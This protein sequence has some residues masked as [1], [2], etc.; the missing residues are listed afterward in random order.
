MDGQSGDKQ[1]RWFRTVVNERCARRDE[2]GEETGRPLRGR[3]AV[4][5]EDI[6]SIYGGLA[7][8]SVLFPFLGKEERQS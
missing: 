1:T 6:P 2:I 8:P 3:R 5:E 7:L 4:G